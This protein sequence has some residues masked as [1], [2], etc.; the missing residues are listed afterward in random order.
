ML[1]PLLMVENA[2]RGTD[3]E[4]LIYLTF[5]LLAILFIFPL[6]KPYTTFHTQPDFL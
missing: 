3:T 5:K 4:A 1:K 6:V 2:G